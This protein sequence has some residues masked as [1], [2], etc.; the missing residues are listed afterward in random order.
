MT[1][2]VVDFGKDS[3]VYN[4]TGCTKEE[5]DNKLNLFF[6]SEGF[7]RKLDTDTEKIFKRGNKALRILLGVFVKYFK[8]AVS[9]KTDG[10]MFSVRLQRD[11]NLLLSGGLIGIAASRKEF[12][13]IGEAF[14]QY[15][16][17]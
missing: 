12:G 6:T 3:F 1:C 13:R 10:Q 2:T 16:N 11:M 17:N 4:I 15:C 8:V 5:L 7:T 9:V 14:K